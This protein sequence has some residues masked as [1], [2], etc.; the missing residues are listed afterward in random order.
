MDWRNSL[1]IP[2]FFVNWVPRSSCISYLYT[3]GNC[4]PDLFCYFSGSDCNSRSVPRWCCHW[5]VSHYHTFNEMRFLPICCVL[6]RCW[7]LGNRRYIWLPNMR[8]KLFQW[9]L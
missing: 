2:T 6:F 1:E 3:S 4:G 7:W 8:V 9:Q 5:Y